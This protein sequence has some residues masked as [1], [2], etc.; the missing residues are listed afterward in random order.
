MLGRGVNK[1]MGESCISVRWAALSCG[2]GE[3]VRPGLGSLLRSSSWFTLYLYHIPFLLPFF[4]KR[5]ILSNL[6]TEPGAQTQQPWDQESHYWLSQPCPS[7]PS[8]LRGRDF[9]F[10]WFTQLAFVANNPQKDQSLA[11]GFMNGCFRNLLLRSHC[12][13]RSMGSFI[14]WWHWVTRCILS[15]SVSLSEWPIVFSPSLS[16]CRFGMRTWRVNQMDS[17]PL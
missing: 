8:F 14:C 17:F 6:N 2:L 10:F 3:C 5:F 9:W 4:F 7:S 12:Y 13:L 1:F 11:S 15:F 16:Q